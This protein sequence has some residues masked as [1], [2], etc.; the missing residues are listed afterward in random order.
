[1]TEQSCT[2]RYGPPYSFSSFSSIHPQGIWLPEPDP[3]GREPVVRVQGDWLAGSFRRHIRTFPGESAS[4][5]VL[6][7]GRLWA[8]G[9]CTA[10]GCI[11]R[12]P[13]RLPAR[14]WPGRIHRGR[15]RLSAGGIR[16][17]AHLLR[18]SDVS[19]STLQHL[20]AGECQYICWSNTENTEVND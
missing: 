17:A 6:R 13:G 10:G 7:P 4:P 12:H 16:T 15:W 1:M 3:V 19:W 5:R 2:T 11:Y 20:E 9:L 14:L 8:G 18:Q